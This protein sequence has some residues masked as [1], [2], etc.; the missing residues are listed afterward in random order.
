MQISQP[1][2]PCYKLS[3]RTDRKDIAAAMITSGRCGWY[4]RTLQSGEID[5]VGTMT[6]IERHQHASTVADTF[7]V[8]FT[9]FRSE[10]SDPSIVERV[11][12]GR[13]AGAR[14]G[15]GGL[16]A[17]HEPARCARINVSKDG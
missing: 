13:R 11:P 16:P 4:L 2:A 10:A 8:M 6:L 9:G 7:A 5:P 15:V 1:R 17:G 3:L 12:C 14:R